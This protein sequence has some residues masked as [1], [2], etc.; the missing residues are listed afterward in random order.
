M[1]TR[2]TFAMNFLF[3]G[4]FAHLPTERPPRKITHTPHT[5][6]K[7]KRH[8]KIQRINKNKNHWKQPNHWNWSINTLGHIEPRQNNLFCLYARD[9]NEG[10]LFLTI[11][12]LR[13]RRL[14]HFSSF[15]SFVRTVSNH[16]KEKILQNICDIFFFG[17][18]ATN[19]TVFFSCNI[20]FYFSLWFFNGRMFL[21]SLN[22]F[23]RHLVRQFLCWHCVCVCVCVF[24]FH[25]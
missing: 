7:Q 10:D 18:H 20:S 12:C 19:S 11:D 8:S 21:M 3:I 5:G 16:D 17:A 15:C 14:F 2:K 23:S 25:T 22:S 9:R 4:C 13:I 24:A 1:I 6:Q